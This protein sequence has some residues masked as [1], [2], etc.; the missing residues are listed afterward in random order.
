[1]FY[2]TFVGYLSIATVMK[3]LILSIMLVCAFGQQGA[4]A[5]SKTATQEPLV[6]KASK[7]WK[8]TKKNIKHAG[9]EVKEAIG[10]GGG[11]KNADGTDDYVTIDDVSYMPLYL[12]NLYS[13]Q[14]AP[15]YT[16][17]CRNMFRHKYPNVR[18]QSV[19]LPQKKWLN[20][21]VKEKDQVK[22]YLQTMYCYVVGKDGTEGYINAKFMFQRY[23]EVGNE[24]GHVVGVWPKWVKTDVITNDIYERLKNK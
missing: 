12:V 2:L 11:S 1:M 5:Q 6:T 17:T 22:G 9:Q 19:V 3:K 18:I 15:V 8:K 4:M 16:D 14:D 21:T 10:I 7:F 13:G 23:R 24:F 20:T